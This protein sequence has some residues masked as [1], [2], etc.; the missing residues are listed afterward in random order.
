MPCL[1]TGLCVLLARKVHQAPTFYACCADVFSKFEKSGWGQ[2]L[3]A[4]VSKATTTDFQ[5]YKWAVAKTKKSRA[6]R[7][8]LKKLQKS[9]S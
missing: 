7:T 1:A 8:E 4:R 9:E 2:K 3:S 5:R 6:V